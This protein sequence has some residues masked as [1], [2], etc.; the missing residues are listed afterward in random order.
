MQSR[1]L[2][3]APDLISSALVDV[4]VGGLHYCAPSPACGG[5][6]PLIPPPRGEGGRPKAG[7]VGGCLSKVIVCALPCANPHPSHRALRSRCATLPTRG[8]D[9]RLHRYPYRGAQAAHRAVA[10]R[11]VAAMRAGDVAGD[12]EAKPGAA[13]VLVAGVVEPQERLEH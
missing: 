13:F 1:M 9:Q 5:A 12:G 3:I 10:E 2:V 8:R 6:R 4:S 11:D 7:G